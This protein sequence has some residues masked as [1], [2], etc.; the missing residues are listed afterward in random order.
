MRATFV[1]L[2][3]LLLTGCAVAGDAVTG[4]VNKLDR[5]ALPESAVVTVELRD[6]SLADAPATTLSTDIIELGGDQLPVPYTLEYDQDEID[7]R[8]NYTVFARI[9]DGGDLLYITDTAYPVITRG[10]PT[11]DVEVFV[12]PV[13]G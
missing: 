4:T 8:N 1:V 6:V 13:G 3:A 9:D 11:E 12:V 2:F 10:N 7:E 5:S